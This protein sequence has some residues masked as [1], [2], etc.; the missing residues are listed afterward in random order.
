[1]EIEFSKGIKVNLTLEKGLRVL[2]CLAHH[3]EPMALSEIVD[4][5]GGNKSTLFRM[6]ET[7]KKYGYVEQERHRGRYRAGLQVLR[8]S[9]DI[10]HRME[11]PKK[12]GPYMH[13][14]A[15]ETGCDIYLAANSNG[16]AIIISTAFPGGKRKTDIGAIGH[17][18]FFQYTAMG[19]CITAYQ[20]LEVI[21]ELLDSATL[22][23]KTANTITDRDEL[24]EEF[25]SVR[26]TGI[27]Y[28]RYEHGENTF[29]A[30]VP[31]RNYEG[32]VIATLGLAVNRDRVEAEGEESFV[33]TI[34]EYGEQL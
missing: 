2:E 23:K 7:L 6:L 29:G 1:L 14:L 33:E 32:E 15:E 34:K 4:N 19:K 20:P 18:N 16:R 5:V 11:L 24:L 26:E 17:E 8:L 13:R 22:E 12:A 30:A 31:V 9:T 27:A 10:L 28:T 3:A 21:N 25:E